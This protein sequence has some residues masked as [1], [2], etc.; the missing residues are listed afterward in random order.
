MTGVSASMYAAGG[1]ASRLGTI[2]RGVLT[3]LTA[4]MTATALSAKMMSMVVKEAATLYLEFNDTLARTGAIL[5]ETE[6]GM[7]AL[8]DKIREVG[9]TTRFTASEV[10]EAANKLAIAGVTADEMISDGAL[11]NLVKFA[12]AGGV[13]I[14]T[15]TNIGIA[16]VKAFGMEM[17][18]L[19]FVSDVLTRTFTRSNVDIVSL[20]EGMKFAAPV[21]HSAGLAIEETAAA[22]GALGNAGLRG[23]VAGTGLRMSINK[24]LK[25]TFD[26][27]KAINDLGLT[28]QVLSPAGEAAKA[29]LSGVASQLDKT[30]MDTGRLTDELRILNGELTGLSIEQQANTLAIE[31]IR[32]RA[33]R[34]NRNL[35]D[36]ELSQISRMEEANDGLRL[37]EME[38]DLERARKS[39]TMS[40]LSEQQKSL[41]TEANSLTKTMEQQTTGLTSLG[42]VLDQL[43][44]GGATT[45]Q[46]LEI[47]GVRGGT[48]MASLLSQR[49]AFHML[50]EENENAAGATKNYMES[51]QGMTD[52]VGSAKEMLFVF[53]SII[54]DGLLTVGKP[55]IDMLVEMSQLFGDDIAK[56]LK[57]NMPLFK[58]LGF[59]IMGMLQVVVPLVIDMLPAMIQSMKAL[60][61]IITILA[62]A[63]RIMLMVLQPVFQLLS[64]I[65]QMIQGLAMVIGGDFKGGGGM[66]LAG[67]KDALIGGAITAL[68]VGTGGGSTAM[69]VAAGALSKTAAK[70]ITRG[71]TAGTLAGGG[72]AT[73]GANLAFS[74]GIQK[75]FAQGGFVSSPTRALVGEDGPEVVIPLGAGK[76]GRRDALM[77]QAGL[78]GMNVNIGDIVINGGSNLSISE[79]RALMSTEMP[80]ILRQELLRGARGVI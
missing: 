20:G 75:K 69:G 25:P 27:Q 63:F 19:G 8:E 22:I 80:R 10:G 73:E 79:V 30:K 39:Q 2:A 67:V 42:D 62:G 41:Q 49:E 38:L 50:V 18:R 77:G 66:M 78:G 74:G 9:R 71:V 35:T 52:G 40:V 70:Q 34:T 6:A 45:T 64:G 31:Q 48:A 37:S 21:A 28:V 53:N 15:A 36:M 7:G 4:A 16:G 43:A 46:V 17:D 12:I 56:A 33:A 26:S 51:L 44:A 61:P 59:Q 11:E 24:L 1:A 57:V 14:E 29:T 47:F 65:G 60:V 23:T 55:F 58:E 13:D 72:Q 32:A 68:A 54:Q 76:E 5:G 3:P